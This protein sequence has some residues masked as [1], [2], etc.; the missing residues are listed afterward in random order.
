LYEKA[1]DR[2]PADNVR[3]AKE[4]SAD[5]VAV[6]PVDPV[7]VPAFPVPVVPAFPVPVVP[8]PAVPSFPVVPF[9]VPVVF[10]TVTE[11]LAPE[12]STGLASASPA[13]VA[14]ADMVQLPAV[15]AL[16]VMLPEEGYPIASPRFIIPPFPAD[17][18]ISRMELS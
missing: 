18:V 3:E 17:E 5:A 4:L 7:P 6:V 10:A 1:G 9:P 16:K 2:V 12:R 11:A 14:V 13:E 8:F 15:F